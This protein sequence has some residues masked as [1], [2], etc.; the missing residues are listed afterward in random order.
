METTTLDSKVEGVDIKYGEANYLV[1][2]SRAGRELMVGGIVADDLSADV[3]T[4]SEG[5]FRRLRHIMDAEGFPTNSIVRQWNYVEGII[6]F[7]GERQHYQDFNDAR[8]RFYA[9]TTWTGGYPAA[10]GIGTRR[11]G[12][13]VELNAL[14]KGEGVVNIPIDNKLQVAA[15]AY[16]QDVLLG[17]V[18]CE[19]Q[20]KTT[21]KFERARLIGYPDDATVYISGTAAIR[22]E[23]SLTKSD[24]TE[25]TRITMENIEFLCSP[26]NINSRDAV[27]TGKERKF[28]LLRVYVKNP[29]RLDVVKRYMDANYDDVPKF[30]LY[31]DVCRT[32]LLVEIEGVASIK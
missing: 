32:E 9:T 13:M 30:Y 21:P 23:D 31:A 17:A 3:L 29:D 8:S 7:E 25:Q 24:E 16:S 26:D 22:G 10:T 1:L 18:D 19:L 11:G 2:E 12:I 4:Q 27:V 6:D 14:V 28:H 20:H 15:H 5:V